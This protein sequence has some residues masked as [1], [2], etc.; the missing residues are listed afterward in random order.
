[1][2]FLLATDAISGKEGVVIAT[3]N[4]TVRE[5][6]ELKS[7]SAKIDKSKKEFKALGYRGTQQK[8]T[9]WSGTGTATYYYVTSEWAKMIIEYAKTG[10]D[11]YFD[12]VV[13]NEDPGSEIGIQ[14][15]KLG[16]CNIDG[17]DISKIDV[18]A[19]WLDGSF[20]FTFSEIDLLDEFKSVQ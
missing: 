2:A 20:N 8:A 9:G 16:Q 15:V 1:M 19:D 11:L 13:T 4:G 7:I 5:L 3:I 10:K 17:V 14:R 18:D 12:I 6:I